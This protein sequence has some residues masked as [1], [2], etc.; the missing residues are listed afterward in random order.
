MV[1]IDAGDLEDF[2]AIVF[3]PLAKLESE[4]TGNRI[5]LRSQHPKREIFCGATA[6]FFVCKILA[7]PQFTP[8][9]PPRIVPQHGNSQNSCHSLVLLGISPRILSLRTISLR[10]HEDEAGVA[11]SQGPPQR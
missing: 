3:H 9:H 7:H 8:P 6:T 10:S 5:S 2:A 1:V 11:S 4:I